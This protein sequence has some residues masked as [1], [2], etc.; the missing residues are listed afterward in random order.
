ML[1]N[2][3][4]FAAF[5]LIVYAIYVCLSNHRYQNLLLLVASYYFYAAWDWRFLAL[6]LGSTLLDYVCALRI[7]RSENPRVRRAFLVASVIGNLS[8]L[9][10]FKYCDFFLGSLE[11]LAGRLGLSPGALRLGI[12]LPVGI[13]FYTFQEMSYTIDVYRRE[14]RATRSL[15]DF[16]T[17]V[18]FFPHMVAG[19]IMRAALLLRQLMAP[20]QITM[21]LLTTGFWLILWGLWKK[22]VI[23]DNVAAIADDVFARSAS[24]TWSMA[25]LGVVAFALQIYCDFSGYSDIARGLARLM[26]IELMQNFNLPYFALNPSDFWRRWHISLSQWLR[27]YLYVPLGGNRGSE[28]KVKRNLAITMLLGGLW[29]GAAWNFVWWGAY[30]GAL[31]IGYRSFRGRDAAPRPSRW[32][33]RAL[34]MFVMFQL[35]LLGWLL[36]RSTRVVTVDN[37]PVDDSWR[38]ILEMLSSFRNGWGFDTGS[39]DLLLHIALLAVPLIVIQVFQHRTLDQFVVLRLP[40]PALVAV[41]AALTLT[42]MLWGVQSG[43][44]FIYFQF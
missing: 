20:R 39:L 32:W 44:A 25:Y 1:F 41:L 9:G 6:L 13:S 4:Q 31:L 29:H 42:W 10:F 7:D 8:L 27:D 34:A 11:A 33:G 3:W 21:D 28:L 5:F 37:R 14:I 12:V 19:P 36:F 26:G 24:V 35:T 43:S 18:A 17:F 2:S 40:R 16:A 23:A 30:H 22:V 38:Q 15:L